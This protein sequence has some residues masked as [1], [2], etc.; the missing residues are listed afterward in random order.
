MAFG[1]KR[2]DALM[3]TSQFQEDCGSNVPDNC[4]TPLQCF[5]F[6]FFNSIIDLIVEQRQISILSIKRNPS[7]QK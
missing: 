7:N 4:S 5:S 2:I 3:T 6:L 1:K